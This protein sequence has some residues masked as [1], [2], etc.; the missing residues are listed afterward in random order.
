MDLSSQFTAEVAYL[1]T[2]TYGLA[3]RAAH[4]AVLAHERDRAAGRMSMPYLDEC[5]ER[6][7]AAFAR[8]VGLTPDRVA[9]GSHVSQFVGLVVASLRPGATVLVA[10]EDFTS[11]LFPF[12]V[13][14]ER[15]VRVRSVP[16][17]RLVDAVDSDVDLVAVSAAQSADGR[18]APLDALCAAAAAHGART[19]VDATQAA[20]WLPLPVDRIDLLVVGGYKWLLGPRGT[21]FF[22][23]TPEAL[24]ELAPLAAGWYAGQDRWESLYGGPLR[25]A[26]DAR[27]FD[28]SPAW[29][30]WVGQAPALELLAGAG[31]PAIGAHNVALANRFRA[32]LGLP[33]GDSAIVSVAVPDGTGERLAAHGVVAASRA[34]RLRCSFHVSTTEADVDLALNLLSEPSLDLG[35]ASPP[36]RRSRR[37]ASPAAGPAR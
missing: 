23:G 16:L 34:G 21:C 33:P 22:G 1:N 28:L 35:P 9:L 36:P 24:A 14:A 13:A 11:V 19:L 12:L 26:G 8:L 17:D 30:C 2:A 15:G 20:G 27:R 18:V 4:E 5:V 31:V 25:L 6:S 29:A 32:G 3:P 10:D 7:R 37:S